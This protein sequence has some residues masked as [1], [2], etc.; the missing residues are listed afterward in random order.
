MRL[1]VDG[2]AEAEEADGSCDHGNDHKRQAEFEPV[3]ALVL[4]GQ[5]D[6]DPVVE[7]AGDNFAD[8]G[9]DE[10]AERLISPVSLMLKL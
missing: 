9:Q 1:V 7:R 2:G 10:R 3:D 8:D 5:V 4:L 6:A